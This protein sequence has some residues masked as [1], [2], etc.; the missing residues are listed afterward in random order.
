MDIVIIEDIKN[1][2][3]RVEGLV[4]ERIVVPEERR[5]YR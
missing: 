4:F 5:G 3:C 1:N 2:F